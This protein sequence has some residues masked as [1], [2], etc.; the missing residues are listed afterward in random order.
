[1]SVY[2]EI[3]SRTSLQTIQL[4]RKHIVVFFHDTR[5]VHKEDGSESESNIQDLILKNNR[6]TYNKVL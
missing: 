2:Q 4:K 5:L 1:M 6:D 3:I